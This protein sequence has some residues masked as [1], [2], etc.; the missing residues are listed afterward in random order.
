MTAIH[1][2]GMYILGDAAWAVIQPSL[3][4]TTTW[5]SFKALVEAQ[6]GLSR[7]R[8]MWALYQMVQRPNESTAQFVRRVEN[9]RLAVGAHADACMQAHCA[10]L[11]ADWAFADRVEALRRTK[12]EIEPGS[13]ATWEMVVAAAQA[14]NSGVSFTTTLPPPPPSV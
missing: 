4:S 11:Q 1:A 12:D 9:E 3:D 6:F 13:V 2:L 14:I 7:P 5:R 8:Q 10:K